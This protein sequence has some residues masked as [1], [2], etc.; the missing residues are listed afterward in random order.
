LGKE[1]LFRAPFGFFMRALG[2]IPVQR[3]QRTNL[4]QQAAARFGQVSRLFLVVPPSGTRSRAPHWKSGFYH[5]ARAAEVP[6]VCTFLDYSRKVA[7]VALV[8]TPTGD[9]AAD[10][11]RIRA[12]YAPILGKH[13]E[14][15]TPVRFL[16]ED[17]PRAESA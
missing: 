17:E 8:L 13:P 6:I 4:V 15:T 16:E 11:D 14:L 1:Q 12:V 2:G 5:I 7:G 9:I 3:G 10:M